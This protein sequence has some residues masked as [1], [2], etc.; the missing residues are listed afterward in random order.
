VALLPASSSP[1]KEK[2]ITH[3]QVSAYN[4]AIVHVFHLA[5]TGASG[6]I[7]QDPSTSKILLWG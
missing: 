6:T 2:G 5:A 3:D 7:D 1:K 4:Q